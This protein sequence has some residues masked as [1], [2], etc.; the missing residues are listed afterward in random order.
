MAIAL[1]LLVQL[2]DTIEGTVQWLSGGSFDAREQRESSQPGARPAPQP[3]AAREPIVL[4]RTSPTSNRRAPQ[5][6]WGGPLRAN[7]AARPVRVVRAEEPR[8]PHCAAGRMVISGRME[9]VCAELDRLA[10]QEAAH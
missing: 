10:A 1:P 8:G 2:F 5:R 6:R 4:S 3:L 9:E 7:A